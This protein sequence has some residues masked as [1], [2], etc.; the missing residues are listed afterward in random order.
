MSDR[1]RAAVDGIE[2][3]RTVRADEL[4]C[5]S[6]A[7]AVDPTHVIIELEGIGLTG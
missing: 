4:C 7:V 2:D 1:L 3:L 6:G 5:G